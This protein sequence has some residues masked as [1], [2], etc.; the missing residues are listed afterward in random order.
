MEITLNQS[1]RLASADHS[2]NNTHINCVIYYEVRFS[3][4]VTHYVGL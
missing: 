3:L 2:C 1:E 4:K